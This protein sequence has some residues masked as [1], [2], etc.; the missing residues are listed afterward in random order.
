VDEMVYNLFDV[1]YESQQEM[2][3]KVSKGLF[4]S[5]STISQLSKD[6]FFK[7]FCDYDIISNNNELFYN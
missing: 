5:W 6:F 4:S 1:K 7:F 3:L 2:I